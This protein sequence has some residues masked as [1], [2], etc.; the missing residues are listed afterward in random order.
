MKNKMELMQAAQ[1]AAAGTLNIV[2]PLALVKAK[3]EAFE[4]LAIHHD[5]FT[6]FVNFFDMARGAYQAMV[7]QPVKPAAVA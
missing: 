3:V 2:A 7:T 1:E 5:H 6:D 4:Q